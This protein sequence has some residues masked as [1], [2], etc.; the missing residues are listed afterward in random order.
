MNIEHIRY[1]E[2]K[3]EEMNLDDDVVRIYSANSWRAFITRHMNDTRRLLRMGLGGGIQFPLDLEVEGYFV[4]VVQRLLK[5]NVLSKNELPKEVI[6]EYLSEIIDQRN[7]KYSKLIAKIFQV[8]FA[9][10]IEIPEGILREALYFDSIRMKVLKMLI[11]KI[12]PEELRMLVSYY[13]PD[14]ER[15]LNSQVIKNLSHDETPSV[16]PA[17][18]IPPHM[19]N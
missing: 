5:M 4:T 18:L 2:G 14:I 16:L 9:G 1:L 12:N 17:N 13:A 11:R 6:L 3:L 8:C 15:A 10:K 19:T 7:R